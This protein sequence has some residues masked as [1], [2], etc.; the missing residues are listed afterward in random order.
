MPEKSITWEIRLCF[1]FQW[2]LCYKSKIL[3]ISRQ[4]SKY[5]GINGVF[6]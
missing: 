3:K 5:S 1:L 6:L 2:K 4:I